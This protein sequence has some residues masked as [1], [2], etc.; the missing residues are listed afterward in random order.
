MIFSNIINKK[1]K[2]CSS[3]LH[4]AIVTGAMLLPHS[5]AGLK[6][7][8]LQGV[9][10]DHHTFDRE[11]GHEHATF[12][13][14]I[15]T[16]GGEVFAFNSDWSH[17]MAQIALSLK[18]DAHAASYPCT[19]IKLE[20]NRDKDVTFTAFG[21]DGKDHSLFAAPDHR[22][23]AELEDEVFLQDCVLS[24][25][26][27]I[28]GSSR[29]LGE[30]ERMIGADNPAVKNYHHFAVFASK[31][32][33][34]SP[35]GGENPDETYEGDPSL[36]TF[37]GG[38]VSEGE[39]YCKGCKVPGG[40]KGCEH[41]NDCFGRCGEGCDCWS[42]IC[43]DCRC[44]DECM[45]HDYYCSCTSAG[46]WHFWCLNGAWALDCEYTS[47]QNKH[48][49]YYC[50]SQTRKFTPSPKADIVSKWVDNYKVGDIITEDLPL[51][52]NDRY[53]DLSLY[54]ISG[55]HFFIGGTID[56]VGEGDIARE[57]PFELALASIDG[58]K[59]VFKVEESMEGLS[60][61]HLGKFVLRDILNAEKGVAAISDAEY[62]LS[63]NTCVHYAQA[64]WRALGAK[65]TKKLADFLIKNLSGSEFISMASA[66]A[67]GHGAIAS[68]AIGGQSAFKYYVKNLVTS[69]LKID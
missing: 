11:V 5:A 6:M 35:F 22:D 12:G 14:T 3:L 25:G 21:H 46:W 29:L 61:H 50:A 19:G 37:V 9:T 48:D 63:R 32:T 4:A 20:Q 13:G 15:T 30:G 28:V 10:V 42:W 60:N 33:E 52:C 62:D 54:A 45:D 36:V 31:I 47:Y 2:S 24:L 66:K 18:G 44:H 41:G 38:A 1:H 26:E 23:F 27:I 7:K 16:E 49:K 67:G 17:T 57:C 34:Y 43:G 65:E 68:L 64:I 56:G 69:Q 40:Y 51:E 53:Y 8:G 39:G 59:K 55:S 58:D